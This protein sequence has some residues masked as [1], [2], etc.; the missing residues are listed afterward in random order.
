MILS[1]RIPRLFGR[2]RH[3]CAVTSKGSP[4]KTLATIAVAAIALTSS[5]SAGVVVT[6]NAG[7]WG[8][9]NAAA[10]VTPVSADLGSIEDGF[11]ASFS[12]S[13]GGID[14]SASAA[15]GL[16]VDN[17]RFSTNNPVPMTFSFG[18]GVKSFAAEFSATDFDFNYLSGKLFE[19]TLSD[20]TSFAGLTESIS[21]PNR[22]FV[23]F[24]ATGSTVITGFTI[25][26][27]S[28]G[29]PDAYATIQDMYLGA[30]PAPGALALIAAAALVGASRRR[31]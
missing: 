4:V 1:M 15:G 26:V 10:G 27:D 14:W 2:Y 3:F 13:S 11:Y 17:G 8:L 16:Y 9:R 31:R 19:I 18:S 7:V 6:T 30:I 24:V 5:A 23:G 25:A 12:S 29:G 21:D 28:L 20:G 22:A